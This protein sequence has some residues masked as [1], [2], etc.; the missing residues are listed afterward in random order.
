MG[1]FHFVEGQVFI[2][3]ITKNWL[4]LELFR[5]YFKN[6]FQNFKVDSLFFKFADLQALY[7]KRSFFLDKLRP[8]RIDLLSECLILV[9]AETI[10]GLVVFKTDKFCNFS[11]M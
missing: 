7:S 11:F 3:K 1:E 10:I 5:N 9:I 2:V 8:Y 6:D 4:S